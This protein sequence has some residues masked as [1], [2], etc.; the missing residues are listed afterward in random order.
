MEIE[1]FNLCM[2]RIKQWRSAHLDQ[3]CAIVLVLY[4]INIFAKKYHLHTFE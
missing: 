1:W 4:I 2:K 3:F